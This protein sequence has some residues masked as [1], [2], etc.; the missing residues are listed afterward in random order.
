M[1]GSNDDDR[2]RTDPASD[3]ARVRELAITNRDVD[4]V[5]D[6][7]C[8]SIGREHL[9]RDIRESTEELVQPWH[10]IEGPK[11]RR[12]AHPDASRWCLESAPDP[13][14]CRFELLKTPR[15]RLEEVSVSV[16]NALAVGP[17]DRA[18]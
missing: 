1:G 4:P 8:R 17:P 13:R 18:P 10:E 15:R 16:G 14:L 11:T 3:Q 9:D 6:E 7:I 5:L 12:N 2:L